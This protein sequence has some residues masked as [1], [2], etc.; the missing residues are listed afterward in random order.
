MLGYHSN[1][2]STVNTFH[3]CTLRSI[4][5]TSEELFV[6]MY[7][8]SSVSTHISL[9]QM[10]EVYTVIIANEMGFEILESFFFLFSKPA[11][12]QVQ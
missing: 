10:C 8:V 1:E 11:N 2:F 5:R 6:S 7:R 4:S 12:G 9:I 3:G